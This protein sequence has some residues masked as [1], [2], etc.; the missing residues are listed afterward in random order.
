MLLQYAGR[1]DVGQK[2][3][4]NEDAFCAVDTY[5]LYVV[6]DGM[7]GHRAGDVAS[8]LATDSIRDFFEATAREDATWPFDFDPNLSVSQNRLMSA[9]KLANRRIFDASAQRKDVQGMG[10]TVVGALF[11]P[12][13][14]RMYIAHVGDSRA[15]RI[16]EGAIEALTRDHSLVNDYL[17]VMPPLTESQRRD[18][19]QNVITRALG[20][21]ESV[22]VDICDDQ[23]KPGDLYV[24]CTDGLTNMLSDEAIL[25]LAKRYPDDLDALTTAL[26]DEANRE[27][28]DDNI[29]V[30]LC[31]CVDEDASEA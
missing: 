6:A 1:T 24:L 28:G 12:S 14:G 5:G 7:G 15:Y 9:I 11:S 10:T 25:R 21:Q 22:V 23:S 27:G 16:R 2:R 19:P 26:I 31:R 20:M 18:L 4:V 30:L 13:D 17:L 3:S 29:T 8:K